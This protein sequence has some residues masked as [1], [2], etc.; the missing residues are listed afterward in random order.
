MRQRLRGYRSCRVLPSPLNIANAVHLF[1]IRSVSLILWQ[2]FFVGIVYYGNLY[3]L[4]IYSQV[5]QKRDSITSGVLLLPLIITQT[6]TATGAG[7]VL[8]QYV[9]M[10]NLLMIALVVIIRLFGLGSLCGLWDWVSKRRSRQISR[11]LKSWDISSLKVS[12]SG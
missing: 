1:T 4:P 3:Y 11:S 8:A 2:T 5:L 12:V 6:F 9:N 7:L 10:K